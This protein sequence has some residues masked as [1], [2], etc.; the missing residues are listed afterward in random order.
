MRSARAIGWAL[1]ACVASG[2]LAGH[3][4]SGSLAPTA[5]ADRDAIRVG[6][7]LLVRARLRDCPDRL[8]LV[9][10]LR[11]GSAPSSLADLGPFSLPGKRTSQLRDEWLARFRE[12]LP[13]RAAPPIEI[14]RVQAEAQGEAMWLRESLDDLGCAGFPPPPQRHPDA[15]RNSVV[16]RIA[17]R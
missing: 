6:D 3:G 8:R 9:D 13:G 14:T 5:R 15:P 11:A 10:V 2:S 7:L 12:R 16:E 1:L 17:V 4:A